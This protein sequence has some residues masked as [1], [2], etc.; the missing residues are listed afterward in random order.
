MLPTWW[1]SCSS[2]W[3]KPSVSCSR[4]KRCARSTRGGVSASGTSARSR[5][6]SRTTSP[7]KR[8][9]LRRTLWHFFHFLEINQIWRFW[10]CWIFSKIRGGNLGASRVLGWECACASSGGGRVAAVLPPFQV[11]HWTCRFIYFWAV[12]IFCRVWSRLLFAP[13]TTTR[14]LF[15]VVERDHKILCN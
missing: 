7:F 10:G 9:P 1:A 6:T 8:Q 13:W 3:C 11:G 5:L 2:T 12:M 14:L 15:L 4:T